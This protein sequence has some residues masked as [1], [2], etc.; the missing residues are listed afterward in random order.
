MPGAGEVAKP[1]DPAHQWDRQQHPGA[2]EREEH[3]GEEKDDAREC[4][5]VM[6]EPVAQLAV[7]LGVL[8]ELA[9]DGAE[10]AVHAP[11]HDGVGRE[12]ERTAGAEEMLTKGRVFGEGDA[13]GIAAGI[14]PGGLGKRD[15]AAG[16]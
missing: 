2:E 1:V 7:A 13:L 15:G 8:E 6:P 11:V 5:G 10:R 9:V 12:I 4:F 16:G 3:E 14:L